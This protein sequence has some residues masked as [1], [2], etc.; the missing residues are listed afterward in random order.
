MQLSDTTNKTGLLQRYE[1]YTNM[2]DGVVTGDSVLKAKAIN[3]LNE[4][5]FDLTTAIMIADDN[6][7]WDDPNRT[8]FPVATTPLVA[9]QRDYQFDSIS[10]LSLRRVDIS[11]DGTTY[12]RAT[13]FDSSQELDGLGNDATVDNRF[14]RTEPMYDPQGS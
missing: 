11:W 12:Y 1:D 8:D 5:L 4:T 13:P 10:F 6:F 9:A 7:Q 2:D 3:D 14:S